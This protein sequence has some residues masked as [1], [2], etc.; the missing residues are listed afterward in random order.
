MASKITKGLARIALAGGILFAGNHLYEQ[1][2]RVFGDQGYSEQVSE[3]YQESVPQE[4]FTAPQN[5]SNDQRTGEP[6]PMGVYAWKIRATFRDG[7][8]WTG[9]ENVHGIKRTYG[10]LTLIR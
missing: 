10:T 1:C 7:F 3:T 9:Q 8:I 4:R 5:Y 2:S 6:A